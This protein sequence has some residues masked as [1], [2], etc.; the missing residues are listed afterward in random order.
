MSIVTVLAI[1]AL[2]LAV[3]AEPSSS[4]LNIP[5]LQKARIGPMVLRTLTAH[6]NWNTVGPERIKSRKVDRLRKTDALK[7]EDTGFQV[8]KF[9][10]QNQKRG[11]FAKP[12]NDVRPK[13]RTFPCFSNPKFV[14]TIKTIRNFSF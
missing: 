10:L 12:E 11:Y 7:S 6:K 2:L 13:C 5:I 1:W 3:Q 4:I 9:D 8:S 14:F